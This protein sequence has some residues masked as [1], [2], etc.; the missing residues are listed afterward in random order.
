M[1]LCKI[2]YMYIHGIVTGYRIQIQNGNVLLICGLI[3]LDLP[4]FLKLKAV[5]LSLCHVTGNK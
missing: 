1:S 5:H 4:L 2:V 3:D